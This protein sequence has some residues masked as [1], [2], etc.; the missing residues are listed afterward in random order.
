MRRYAALAGL[1][2][3][4]GPGSD[5]PAGTAADTSGTSTTT[6]ST[7]TPSVETKPWDI[8]TETNP[9]PPQTSSTTPDPTTATDPPPPPPDTGESGE[10]E[11]DFVGIFGFGM[12]VP[13]QSY[14]VE[15]ETIAFVDG[16]DLC[17]LLWT[18]SAVPDDTCTECD[19][20]FR[21]TIDTVE[22]EA[23]VDCAAYGWAPAEVE[24]SVIAVGPAPGED[25]YVDEGEGW[26]WSV[27]GFAEY[28]EGR[29]VFEWEHP[30]DAP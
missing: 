10:V 28:I 13:G 15:G 4:C 26:T 7:T 14:A 11:E 19:F 20:A 2:A 21:L 9:P 12:A 24:G 16:E 25:L 29:G 23:D 30:V 3:A 27:E 17:V 22:V 5:D 8:E 6:S 18:A 1:L